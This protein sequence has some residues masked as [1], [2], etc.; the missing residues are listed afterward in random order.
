MDYIMYLILAVAVIMI[1]SIFV[2]RRYRKL[3]QEKM[4]S[5][6]GMQL[7]CTSQYGIFGVGPYES[8]G[9]YHTVYK[10]RYM[11][12]GEV[13]EGWVKFSI[14]SKPDWRL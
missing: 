8:A 10:L 5:F 12:N 11:L 6:G 14:F 4:E 1:A 9:K 3:I 7:S 2:R 13:R